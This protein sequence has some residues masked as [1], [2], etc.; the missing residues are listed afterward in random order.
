MNI[1]QAESATG[2]S[3]QNIRFY[4][5]QGLLHPARGAE[6][7]Y[8]DYAP[9][10]IRALKRIKILRKLG[11]SVPIVREVLAGELSLTDA[12]AAQQEALKQQR[13]EVDAALRVCGDL[14]GKSLDAIDE[15]ACLAHIE[16]QEQ[17][18]HLFMEIVNDF[19][20][21]VKQEGR[22]FTFSPDVFVENP[23]EF[24]SELLRYAKEHGHD[25]TITKE[26]M[27]PH[28]T[29]DGVEYTA[30][31]VVGRFG[32]V[33]QCTPECLAD[34]R[35]ADTPRR[36]A[37]RWGYRLMLPT[38]IFFFAFFWFDF[39]EDALWVRL[40]VGIGLTADAI[41]TGYLYYR[42]RS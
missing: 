23:R 27:Y 3:K 17:E 36:R 7:D 38:L 30:F 10:D 26:S 6:N 16:Q 5:A 20:E 19:K 35:K 37:L 28:F 24:T 11:I 40:L 31:R 9:A 41:A 39:G 42:N 2:I 22:T 21:V 18:G 1:K 34:E 29:L 15:D 12:L 4:E 13:A 8:R 25:I 32:A 33:V 14:Q